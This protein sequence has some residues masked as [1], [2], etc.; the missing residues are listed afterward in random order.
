LGGEIWEENRKLEAGNTRLKLELRR[1]W[2][3]LD[4]SRHVEAVEFKPARGAVKALI[5]AS[6][7]R[8]VSN[9]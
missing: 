3:P 1:I 4:P 8:L 9:I 6:S 5:K 7:L 2:E